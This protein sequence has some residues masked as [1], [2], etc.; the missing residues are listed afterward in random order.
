[1][2]FINCINVLY[3][4]AMALFI[5]IAVQIATEGVVDFR[6]ATCGVLLLGVVYNIYTFVGRKR[7]K[8]LLFEGLQK[9]IW[10][11]HIEEE[12]RKDN[13]FMKFSKKVPE[14]SLL[15]GRVVHIQQS[16]GSGNVIKNRQTLPA[17]TRKRNDS[18]LVYLLNDFT[19]D[20]V[21]IPFTEEKELSAEYRNSVLGEDRDNLVENVAENLIVD[22]LQSDAYSSYAASKLTDQNGAVLESTGADGEQ[23]NHSGDAARKLSTINDLQRMRKAFKD[24]DRWF[25]NK[26]YALLTPQQEIEMFPAD[27]L[28]T[29][30]YM[31]NVTEEERR[32]GIMYKAQGWKLMSR[33]SVAHLAAD[34]TLKLPGEAL[35]ATDDMASMF[36]YEGAVEHTVGAIEPFFKH[37]D[38]NNY[39]DV[40]SFLIYS[41]G[42]ARR[43]DY[44]GIK[45]LKQAKTA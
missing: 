30:T 12:I 16:G 13:T 11:D 27:N 35:V 3:N 26:M 37:R 7:L 32:S 18:D 45:L 44:K 14:Q 10:T 28:I 42:R 21:V 4:I 22:W 5:G 33:S 2:K 8:G 39:G 38:P 24:D 43:A 15:G 9:E 20:P 29:A 6:A 25:E 31:Q 23:N 36:W 40:F 17:K 41:G 34:G 19:T 1:M